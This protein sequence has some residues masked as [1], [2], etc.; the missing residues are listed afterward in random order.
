L[1]VGERLKSLAEKLFD[2]V[3]DEMPYQDLLIK[4]KELTTLGFFFSSVNK[5]PYIFRYF[6]DCNHRKFPL[7]SY[8]RLVRDKIK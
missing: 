7:N 5:Y 6:T 3:Q 8:I 1:G 4:E 2:N